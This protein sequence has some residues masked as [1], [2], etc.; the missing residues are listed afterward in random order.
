MSLDV[1]GQLVVA[2]A[3]A[4]LLLLLLQAVAVTRLRHACRALRRD[5]EALQTELN[6]LC[7]GASS[8]GAHLSRVDQQLVRLC[9]R[10]DNLE[11]RDSLHREYD[12]AV[13]LVRSGADVEE[14]MS[15]C[16]LLRTE[17]ELLM[18]LHGGMRAPA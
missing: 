15:Q 1:A 6:A 12:R 14:I 8:L 10:Q 13:R 7:S 5:T 2:V 16:N 3:S 17:A 4:L 11:A 9:E 18:R